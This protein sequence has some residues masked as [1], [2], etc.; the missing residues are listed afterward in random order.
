MRLTLRIMNECLGIPIVMV[1]TTNVPD[2]KTDSAHVVWKTL[3]FV[4]FAVNCTVSIAEI[5]F[6]IW[7]MQK[8]ASIILVNMMLMSVK[9]VHCH[10]LCMAVWYAMAFR[11]VSV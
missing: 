11:V 9:F 10:Q 5:Q 8:N 7:K 2:V 6:Q 1:F 3:I 4:A